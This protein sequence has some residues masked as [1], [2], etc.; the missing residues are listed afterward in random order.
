MFY[1]VFQIS[2]QKQITVWRP[3]FIELI[4]DIFIIY[5]SRAPK[6]ERFGFWTENNGSVVKPFVFRTFGLSTSQHSE[7]RLDRF[8][9]KKIMTFL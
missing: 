2:E 8:I 1:V 6:S 5:Y 7:I 3:I 9:Y 4:L